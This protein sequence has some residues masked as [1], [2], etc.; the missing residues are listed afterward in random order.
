MFRRPDRKSIEK[1]EAILTAVQESHARRVSLATNSP[2]LNQPL[3]ML[4]IA[5][6][7][8]RP[9]IEIYSFTHHAADG[10]PIEDDFRQIAES[11]LV[12]FQSQGAALWPGWSNLRVSQYEEYTRRH[13]GSAPFKVFDDVSIYQVDH[14]R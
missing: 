8:S 2:S 13:S 10:W 6:S 1:S 7:S 11:D 4:A 5:I 14:H 9:T 12:V 3:L